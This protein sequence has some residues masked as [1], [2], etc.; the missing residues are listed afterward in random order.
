MCKKALWSILLVIFLCSYTQASFL[1]V[2][3]DTLGAATTKTTAEG[4]VELGLKEALN[5]GVKNSIALL[6]KKDGYFADR[7]VKILL[8]AEV[9]KRKRCCA[10]PGSVPSLTSSRSA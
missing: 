6:G 8:P 7:A 10:A 2:L 1:D 5:V 4:S 3:K 9:Q